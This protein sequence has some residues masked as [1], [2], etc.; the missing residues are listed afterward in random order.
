M[1]SLGKQPKYR[2]GVAPLHRSGKEAM[3]GVGDG[4][5]VGIWK[6]SEFHPA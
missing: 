3:V 5:Y 6:L 1:T 4:W 2:E